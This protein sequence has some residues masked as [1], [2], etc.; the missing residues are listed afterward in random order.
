MIHDIVTL[1]GRQL[2]L[3]GARGQSNDP[4]PATTRNYYLPRTVNFLTLGA[5]GIGTAGLMISLVLFAI[6]AASIGSGPIGLLIIVF[7]MASVSGVGRLHRAVE[8]PTIFSLMADIGVVWSSFPA[9]II[10][11]FSTSGEGIACN[12]SICKVLGIA[13][14]LLLYTLLL[15]M[16]L[17]VLIHVALLAITVVS[18][19]VRMISVLVAMTRTYY[20]QIPGDEEQSIEYAGL[21]EQPIVLT[22]GLSSSGSAA[23]ELDAE[24]FGP[25][26]GD[27]M[28]SFKTQQG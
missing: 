22:V 11:A 28:S 5:I 10:F 3:G 9:Y 17:A 7:W 25:W 6:C 24:E 14:A 18:L 4:P 20:R 8:L 27:D 12:L 15:L 26:K 16:A 2:F 19:A 21:N 1:T 23:Y 13:I